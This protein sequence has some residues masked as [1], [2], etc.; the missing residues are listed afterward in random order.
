MIVDPSKAP[1]DERLVVTRYVGKRRYKRRVSYHIEGMSKGLNYGVFN[2][3]INSLETAVK[4][5]VLYVKTG[6][7]GFGRPP[8]PALDAFPHLWDRLKDSLKGVKFAS[9]LTEDQFLRAYEGRKRTIYGKAIESLKTKPL[10]KKDSFVKYFMKV[11][12]VNFTSKPDAVCRGISPRDPRFHVSLGPYIKRIEKTIYKSLDSMWGYPTV[13]KGHNAQKRGQLVLQHWN[14]YND[15]VAVGIDASRF[16]QHVSVDA[17]KFEHDV[18]LSYFTGRDR[19]RLSKLLKKQLKNTGVGYAQDGKLKFTVEGVRMSGD[20]N[21]SLG[22]VLLMCAITYDL[23]LKSGIE[24]SFINDGDDGVLFMERKDLRHISKLLKPHYLNYGFNVV[25]EEPVH[26]LEH[27][28][29]CQCKPIMVNT[30]ECVMVRN[31]QVSFDKDTC[32][33]LPINKTS[34]PKWAR[35]VGECGLSLAGNVPV[36]CEFYRS[37]MKYTTKTIALNK[38]GWLRMAAGMTPKTGVSPE[39]RCSYW[40][41]FGVPPDMQLEQERYYKSCLVDF[42]YSHTKHTPTPLHFL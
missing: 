16:D 41:A 15:P 22:N 7:G 1:D 29:F 42:N 30:G 38:E 21:T 19:D 39:A 4:E 26:V 18:Y 28:E 14:M 34:G 24:F 3:D 27:I 17:L 35:A 31:A 40:K 6:D 10:C 37:L 13:M 11:E 23:K 5:R 8:Q 12:K 25:L 36:L 9:P 20:M 33:I 2:S 32:S